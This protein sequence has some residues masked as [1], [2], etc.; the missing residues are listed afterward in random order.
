MR[1]HNTVRPPKPSGKRRLIELGKDLLILLLT[2]SAVALAAQTGLY[3]LGG[4][5]SWVGRLT[6]LI[7]G[8]EAPVPVP[9]EQD[10]LGIAPQPVRLAVCLSGGEE[11]RRYGVQYDQEQVDR[12]YTVLSSFLNEALASAHDPKLILDQAWQRALGTPGLYFD[13][14]GGVPLQALC[15]WASEGTGGGAGLPGAAR[16]LVLAAEE[17]EETATLY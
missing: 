2:F 13:L 12:D 14:L 11:V 4:G 8:G 1:S 17:G 16:H 7:Q 10:G 15:Q 3:G 9:G 5:D 6:G